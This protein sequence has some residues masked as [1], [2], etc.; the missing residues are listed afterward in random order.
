MANGEGNSIDQNHVVKMM[1]ARLQHGV[2][3]Q[4]TYPSDQ[5]YCRGISQST[6]LNFVVRLLEKN[7]HG[8]KNQSLE[9]GFLA[10]PS[11]EAPEPP[12]SV[13]APPAVAV[14]VTS[15]RAKTLSMD[16]IRPI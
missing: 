4:E 1:L 9:I 15:V 10:P 2:R 14:V 11:S 16:H 7:L 13:P 5:K 6:I 3:C 8:Q 12:A